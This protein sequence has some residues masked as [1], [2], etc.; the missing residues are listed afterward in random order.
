M[1]YDELS[2]R[3]EKLVS[4]GETPSNI[5]NLLSM[6]GGGIRGLVILQVQVSLF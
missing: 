4:S 3:L 1:F 2:A 6:D 5:I